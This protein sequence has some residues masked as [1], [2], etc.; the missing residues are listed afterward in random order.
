[1]AGIIYY[2]LDL[3][4]N[5]L[6]CKDD[7]HEICELSI[8]R[9]SD[10]VQ[11]TR[12]VKV[13]KPQNSSLDAL[14][15]IKK[16]AQDLR[17]GISKEQLVKDV[18]DFLSEDGLNSAHRCLIGHNII[19]F[20]KK[21]LWRLWERHNKRFPFDL[22]LDTF[23]MSKAHSKKLG[24]V[25]PQLNLKAACDLFKVKTVD[26]A[27]QALA[28]TRNAYLL[29]RKLMDEMDYLPLIKRLPHTQ[30]E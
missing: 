21:F 5:G 2:V 8:L 24:I 11:L 28:D 26:G 15:I 29:W 17:R 16:T 19:S 14:K 12:E 25:K 4:T 22:Y 6:Q 27:H 9:A 3:E 7:F 23:Q 18:E 1:M 13:D 30:D 20:D 10:R